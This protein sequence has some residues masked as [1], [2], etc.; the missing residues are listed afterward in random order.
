MDSTFDVLV[1]NGYVVAQEAVVDIA[2]DDG[3][4]A[5]IRPEI[6]ESGDTELDARGDLVSP[7]LV[8]AHV[9]LDMA[10][11]ATGDRRP[12]NNER[13]TD[14]ID[15]IERTAAY[16]AE[17]DGEEIEARVRDVAGRAVTNGVLHLRT[18]AYVDSE[19]GTD[20][21]ER[22]AAVREAFDDRLDVEIVAFPQG[23]IGRDEGSADALRAALDAGADLVGGLD[24]ATLNGDR[25]GTIETWFDVATDGDADVDVHIH[26]RGDTGTDT[27]RAL[28]EATIDRGYEGRVTAS[29]A[30]ALAD[31]ATGLDGDSSGDDGGDRGGRGDRDDQLGDAMET[32]TAA[33]LRFVTCY[34]STPRGMPIRRVHDA[35]LVLAHGTDQVHD[36][37]G[38]HGNLN[39]IEAM[40][41][42]SLKLD[43]YATNDGLA[44][45]WRLIT[46]EGASLLGRAEDYGIE[47]GTPA[48]LVVHDAR[49]PQWAILERN[50]PRYVLKN[51][52]VVA[53]DGSLAGTRP[54]P[55]GRE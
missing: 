20:I 10:L 46:T 54:S 37:W 4:I 11:S 18:H 7:G 36:M 27:L 9:H 32:F 1:R 30:Y 51:G 50:D 15:A 40:L 43:G 52:N 12:R 2:I 33:D 22:V 16:F 35:G 38:A 13:R 53:A 48:D 6:A 39:A 17:T 29:H 24:P 41:V 31:A 23:G 28:A 3:R 25:T 55:S 45:L 19:V 26:E 8:D 34:G 5:A 44:C 14:R 21:V 47:A 49:S 42:Q